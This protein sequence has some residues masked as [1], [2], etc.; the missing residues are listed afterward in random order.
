MNN[1]EFFEKLQ[2]AKERV[3]SWPEWKKNILKESSKS[4][5]D[6]PREPVVKSSEEKNNP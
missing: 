1:K 5:N 3:K 2:P 4:Y 6:V